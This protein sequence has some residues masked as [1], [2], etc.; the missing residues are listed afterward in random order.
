MSALRRTLA[1]ALPTAAVLALGVAPAQADVGIYC[2]DAQ[3]N[4]GHFY[5]NTGLKGSRT[6]FTGKSGQMGSISNLAGYTFLSSGAGQG[7]PVKNNAASFYNASMQVATVFYSSQYN[8]PCDTVAKL[9]SA[10]QLVQTYNEN[11]S[12]GFGLIGQN[13]HMFN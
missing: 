6:V 11:A 13:C 7:Q 5:Y 3:A 1:V 10:N 8:G 9:T 2:V 12:L 4:C